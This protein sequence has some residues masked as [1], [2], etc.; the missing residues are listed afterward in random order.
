M[1]TKKELKAQVEKLAEKNRTL[2]ASNN[3]LIDEIDNLNADHMARKHHT[4]IYCQR[5]EHAIPDVM[6]MSWF[7]DLDVSCEDFVE[8]K[9][10]DE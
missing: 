3:H 6:G 9:E 7:C 5:C 8:K 2:T 10:N 1:I 4:N